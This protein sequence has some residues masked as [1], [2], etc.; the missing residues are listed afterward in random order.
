MTTESE[1]LKTVYELLF[2]RCYKR[3][4]KGQLGTMRDAEN[5]ENAKQIRVLFSRLYVLLGQKRS[6]KDGILER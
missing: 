1:E 5:C 3:F 4:I 2:Q 6:I